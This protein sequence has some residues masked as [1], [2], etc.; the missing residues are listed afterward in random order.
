MNYHGHPFL[1]T[2]GMILQS[3]LTL[4]FS[5]ALEYS[6]WGRVSVLGTGFIEL[7][8]EA[9]L[10]GMESANSLLGCPFTMHHNSRLYSADLPTLTSYYLPHNPIS[11]RNILPRHSITFK[12][13]QE[14]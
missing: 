5:L 6:S 13:V 7:K 4:V 2:Y 9:F 1:R 8:L 3:S 14:Y 12:K 11:G 10:R